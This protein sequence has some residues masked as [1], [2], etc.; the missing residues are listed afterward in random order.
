MKRESGVSLITLIVTIMVMFIL[1]IV[2]GKYTLDNVKEANRAA[3]LKEIAQVREYV[4][5]KQANLDTD[6][7]SQVLASHED[8][9]ITAE[10]LNTVAN[11]KLSDSEVNAIN[12][13]NAAGLL[14][15]YKYFYFPKSGKYFEDVEF[16]AG[17]LTVKDVKNDYIVNFYT[18]TVI[19]LSDENFK[20]D[21]IVKGLTQIQNE[22][23][24]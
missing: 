9:V 11:G 24:I 8:L 4:I 3:E 14:P 17:G 7:V 21:G 18:A 20:V 1:I 6:E 13:V 16:S 23:N 2:V 15:K 10:L 22:L 12:D 5:D 19:C